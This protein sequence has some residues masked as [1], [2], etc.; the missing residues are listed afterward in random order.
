M[1]AMRARLALI[2]G[3]KG[4]SKVWTPYRRQTYNRLVYAMVERATVQARRLDMDTIHLPSEDH[5]VG[6][7]YIGLRRFVRNY[8]SKSS[9]L[10]D[11]VFEEEGVK[12]P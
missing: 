6:D 3:E 4:Y 9:R 12:K 8:M 1:A 7:R 5:R 2:E 10:I 11:S